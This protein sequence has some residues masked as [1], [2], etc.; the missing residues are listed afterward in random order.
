MIT[1]ANSL[2]LAIK[3]DEQHAK[4]L[5]ED[6]K[7]IRSRFDLKLIPSQ[8]QRVSLVSSLI[9]YGLLVFV[10]LPQKD[11]KLDLLFDLFAEEKLLSSLQLG[12]PSILRYLILVFIVSHEKKNAK[13]D[14][15]Q[16][17]KI[18]KNEVFPY[19]DVYVDLI[20][21]LYISFDLEAVSGL[22]QK[23]AEETKSDLVF[24]KH[25]DTVVENSRK[26]YF[27]VYCKVYN[28]VEI[29]QVA[30][31][32]GTDE[33][34]AE[35]WIVNLLRRN[36]IAASVDSS[37]Q[38]LTIGCYTSDESENLN[39]RAKELMSRNKIILNNATKFL[40]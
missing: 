39:K 25:V 31:F 14:Q 35:I 17:A 9:Y 12:E 28:A 8:G 24:S 1:K 13:L 7:N 20:D 22:I 36:N 3:G 23:I 19:R 2:V 34:T 26:M 37:G 18:V 6:F 5:A 40:S 38:S 15:A 32:I 16:L 33:E 30:D 29:K 27:E 11:L 10:Y 21:A 4:A